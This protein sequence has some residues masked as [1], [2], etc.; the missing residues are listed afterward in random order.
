[1]RFPTS[2]LRTFTEESNRIEGIIRKPRPYEIAA[3]G[4]LLQ[5][6][7]VDVMDVEAFVKAIAPGHRL[8]SYPGLNVRVGKYEA[9][10][11]GPDI[12]KRLDLLLSSL[13]VTE[14]WAWHVAYEKLHPFTDGNG[15][16]GR[17]LWL[18]CHSNSVFGD[19]D[20]VKAIGFLHSFYYETLQNS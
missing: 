1:M 17:A 2:F 15:R 7:P 3:L 19:L 20:R 16:S 18:W 10:A 12:L 11:G 4:Q 5:Q 9:P 8:R 14:P 13:P 6:D